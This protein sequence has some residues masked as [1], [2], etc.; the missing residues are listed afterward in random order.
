M[1]TMEFPLWIG[2]QKMSWKWESVNTWQLTGSSDLSFKV[3]LSKVLNLVHFLP[4]WHSYWFSFRKIKYNFD[5]KWKYYANSI[6]HQ[7]S[8]TSQIY[9]T[10]ARQ[11]CQI[12]WSL[13]ILVMKNLNKRMEKCL[14]LMLDGDECIA[15]LRKRRMQQNPKVKISLKVNRSMLREFYNHPPNL[16]I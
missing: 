7:L 4:N 6:S 10:G 9:S 12:L 16:S 5:W 3:V 11:I 13:W 8:L 15:K 2:L 14:Y 1:I